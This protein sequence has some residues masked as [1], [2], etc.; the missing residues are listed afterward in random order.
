MSALQPTLNGAHCAKVQTSD[1]MLAVIKAAFT[2]CY[3][4]KLQIILAFNGQYEIG[5][6]HE[7]Y[8]DSTLKQRPW[9]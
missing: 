4:I 8:D 2:K 7:R 5:G 3:D 9:N 1:S 6:K